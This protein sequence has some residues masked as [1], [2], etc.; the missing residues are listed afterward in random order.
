MQNVQ[1]KSISRNA[2]FSL[3]AWLLP[4][5]LSL[6]ATPLIL[7]DLGKKDYGVYVLIL[8]FIS[9]SFAFS[10]GRSI[11]K[12]VAQYQALGEE[13]K[14]SEV[15]STALIINIFVGTFAVILPFVF[16]RWFV[17]DIL[18]IEPNLRETALRGFYLTGLI[19][20]ATILSQ[21]YAA[22]LQAFHRFD[23]F[24]IILVISNTVST[25]GNILI[26]YEGGKTETLLVWNLISTVLTT[27]FYFYYSRKFV[28]GGKFTFSVDKQIFFQVGKYNLSIIC[29]QIFSNALVLFERSWITKKY[30]SEN[31]T[32]Y[33]IP[34][35]LSMLIHI[36]IA[37]IVVVIFP[38]A[39][40][41][42][43]LGEREKILSIYKK[44]TKVVLFCSAFLVM[45]MIIGR[46]VILKSWVADNFT[47]MSANILIFHALTFGLLALS[48]VFWQIAEGFGY[49]HYTALLSVIWFLITVPLMIEFSGS[50]SLESIASARLI[51]SLIFI[52][53][54][55]TAEKKI[56][57]EILWGFWAKSLA[58]IALAIIISGFFEYQI[59]NSFN[60]PKIST[61]TGLF[62]G[63]IIF[64]AVIWFGRYFD[65]AELDS[66]YRLREIKLIKRMSN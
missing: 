28:P 39:S 32:L 44:T 65:K 42:H 14:I 53:A 43:A 20:S 30:G 24:S 8:G 5:G 12:F 35:M 40:E 6:V 37:N 16:A 34:M 19:V 58:V 22:I 46:N 48:T 61:V 27:V 45:S 11:T 17:N 25:A 63:G 41:S 7:K 4:L 9:Y 60:S 13:K 10:I 2:F 51:G 15:I 33:M 56:F 47:E 1:N 55:L 66:L 59:F 21:I 31:L 26:V 62:I 36:F 64:L 52:P 57:G 23:I 18:E 29:M 3:F 49:P 38:L 50:Y 54:I